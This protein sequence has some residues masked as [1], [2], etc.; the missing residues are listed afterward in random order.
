M[1]SHAS[2]YSG[3]ATRWFAV[4]FSIAILSFAVNSNAQLAGTGSIQGSITDATGALIANATVTATNVA[5]HCGYRN[6][7]FL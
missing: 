7:R 4:V 2:H 1:Q 5:T 6:K 3:M